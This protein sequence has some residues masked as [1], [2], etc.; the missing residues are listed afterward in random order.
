MEN[1]NNAYN[2]ANC[3]SL[4]ISNLQALSQNVVETL[5]EPYCI[6]SYKAS[7]LLFYKET[8]Q[9]QFGSCSSISTLHTDRGGAYET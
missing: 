9:N 3:V 1:G 4:V 7:R 5:K 8:T 6:P 2:H